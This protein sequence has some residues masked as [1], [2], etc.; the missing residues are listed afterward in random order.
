MNAYTISK[1]A[2][3]A[4]VSVHVARDYD[5]RGLIQSCKCTKNGYRI[6]NKHAL[7]RLEFV[8]TGKAAGISLCDLTKLC[9]A[10]DNK[11]TKKL[12]THLEQ[13]RFILETKLNTQR[14][15]KR[16]LRKIALS[17]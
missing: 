10:I 14:T 11:N 16:L 8:L 6:Y 15:F 12:D 9:H 5:L 17:D 2:A 3:D 1:L 4:G 7:L 13:I